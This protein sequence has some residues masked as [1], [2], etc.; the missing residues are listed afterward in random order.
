MSHAHRA[1]GPG[2]GRRR[3][4]HNRTIWVIPYFRGLYAG[5]EDEPTC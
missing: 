4:F 3:A 1:V 2:Y 5:P